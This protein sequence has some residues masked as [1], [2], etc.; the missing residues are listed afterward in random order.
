MLVKKVMKVQSLKQDI[1]KTMTWDWTM[2][3][4]IYKDC[5]FGSYIT[6][7]LHKIKLIT[8]S[9]SAEQE[10]PGMKQVFKIKYPSKSG[11]KL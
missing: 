5:Y 4:Y 1:C 2:V 10:V 9:H 7:H 8:L 6:G 11:M 3:I